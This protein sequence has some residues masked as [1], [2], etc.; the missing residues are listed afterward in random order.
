MIQGPR[1]LPGDLGALMERID[2]CLHVAAVLLMVGCA[3]GSKQSASDATAEELV[4]IR[5]RIHQMAVTTTPERSTTQR[6]I[7]VITV[8]GDTLLLSLPPNLP[9][10]CRPDSKRGGYG[11]LGLGME[12]WVYLPTR[13]AQRARRQ[14]T[15]INRLEVNCE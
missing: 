14:R 8:S 6:S 2:L 10:I 11:G 3:G 7:D 4:A 9:A 15:S 5:G 1:V 12:V 13:D